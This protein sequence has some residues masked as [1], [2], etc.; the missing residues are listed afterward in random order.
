MIEKDYLQQAIN[1]SGKAETS[2][3]PDYWS[4]ENP[5]IGHCSV[6]ALIV[7]DLLGGELL[8]ASLEGTEFEYGKSHYWNRLQDGTEVDFTEVQFEG[9]KPKLVGEQ[10]TREYVLSYEPTKQRYELLKAAVLRVL[11]ETGNI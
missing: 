5:T 6:V 9:R 1:V 2:A 8:R 3:T 10:R 7:Q 11:T 4:E